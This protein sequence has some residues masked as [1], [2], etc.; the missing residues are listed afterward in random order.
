MPLDLRNGF[1]MLSS[2]LEWNLQSHVYI[3]GWCWADFVKTKPLVASVGTWKNADVLDD[4]LL[5]M[6][7]L[8]DEIEAWKEARRCR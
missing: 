4:E 2:V 5:P 3:L 7:R 8:S 6:S 1:V